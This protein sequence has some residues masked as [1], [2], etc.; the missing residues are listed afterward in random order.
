MKSSSENFIQLLSP[1]GN[2][3]HKY[4]MQ[5]VDKLAGDKIKKA[6][7]NSF[8][9]FLGLPIYL[10]HPDEGKNA[11]SAKAV[12][13]VENISVTKEGIA[14]SARYFPETQEKL[15]SGKI[16][17][18]S[19]RWRMEK[20]PDGTFRPV[21]LISVGLTNNPNIPRAGTILQTEFTQDDLLLKRTKEAKDFCLSAKKNAETAAEKSAQISKES[22][23][24]KR[25]N[26]DARL[27]ESFSSPL[28]HELAQLAMQRSKET[29]ESYLD[30]F[31]T[32]RKKYCKAKKFR[33]QEGSLKTTN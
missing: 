18:L 11:K 27:S 24:L 23:R 33:E 26:L 31:T 28:P 3:Q 7:L 13:R 1:Y 19:P 9:R 17:W 25:E 8:D 12:G 20:L 6:F 4:G 30:A 14:I 29:G 15:N 22:E 16:K 2:W 10:G 5:I 21:K 32:L